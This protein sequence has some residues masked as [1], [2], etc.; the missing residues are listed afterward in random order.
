MDM[1]IRWI[2]NWPIWPV[3]CCVAYKEESFTLEIP[4]VGDHDVKYKLRQVCSSSYSIP[5]PS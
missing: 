3:A 5:L 2:A 4:G 1:N